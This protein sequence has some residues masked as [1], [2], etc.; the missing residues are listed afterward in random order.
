MQTNKV[1]LFKTTC[2]CTFHDIFYMCMFQTRKLI[3]KKTVVTSTGTV[4]YTSTV[5]CILVRVRLCS[6]TGSLVD[7]LEIIKSV[8]TVSLFVHPFI[9]ISNYLA[10]YLSIYVCMYLSI[11]VCTSVCVCTYVS[12]FIKHAP[13]LCSNTT[14]YKFT[15]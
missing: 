13:L 10:V 14:C 12:L 7:T 1:N 2:N 9:I 3:F 6:G 8:S 15:C 4:C 11:C 5:W